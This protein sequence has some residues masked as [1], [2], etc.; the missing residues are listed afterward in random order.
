MGIEDPRITFLDGIFYLVY[1]VY[2]GKN[3]LVAYATSTDLAHF[4]KQGIISPRISYREAS[5]LFAHSKVKL[6]ERYFLF[7]NRSTAFS[8]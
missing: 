6:R 1:T 5:H 8:D 2:D 4:V 3:A 7:D